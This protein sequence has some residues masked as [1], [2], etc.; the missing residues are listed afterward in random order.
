MRQ[1]QELAPG[2]VWEAAEDEVTTKQARAWVQPYTTE[3][4][5]ESEGYWSQFYK[6]AKASHPQLE[7]SKKMVEG[8][9]SDII[10]KMSEDGDYD[11]IILVGS[12]WG[13][14]GGLFLGSVSS[15]VVNKANIP[16]TVVK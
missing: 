14:I 1:Y 3:Y 12:G 7:I 16:V 5:K 9:P 13:N 2:C 10:L 15:K 6:R 11:M 8:R 4:M